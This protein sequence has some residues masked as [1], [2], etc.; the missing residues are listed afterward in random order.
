[1][2]VRHGPPFDYGRCKPLRLYASKYVRTSVAS[3]SHLNCPSFTPLISPPRPR[4]PMITKQNRCKTPHDR[5]SN[6][7]R[8]IICLF[9]QRQ[10]PYEMSPARYS[11]SPILSTSY[12]PVL[13]RLDHPL[14]LDTIRSSRQ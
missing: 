5:R 13:R 9:D 1:M 11:H 12:P 10:L 8:L 2:L 4:R 14:Q 3:L 6:I 7:P